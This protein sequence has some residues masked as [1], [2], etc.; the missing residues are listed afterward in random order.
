M[1]ESA[2]R[3]VVMIIVLVM[4]AVIGF[5]VWV[6]FLTRM[7]LV[8]VGAVIA[9]VFRD[10]NPNRA[11]AGL[12]A[13]ITF[14]MRGFRMIAGLADWRVGGGRPGQDQALDLL[15][16]LVEVGFAALFWVLVASGWWI[17]F[18]VG[19]GTT[20]KRAD[21]PGFVVAEKQEVVPPP[22][23]RSSE[24]GPANRADEPTSALARPDSRTVDV[25]PGAQANVD[26]D[27][28]R[29]PADVVNADTIV[30][31]G[32][33]VRRCK[34]RGSEVFNVWCQMADLRIVGKLQSEECGSDWGE[35]DVPGIARG[36][37]LKLTLEMCGTNIDGCKRGRPSVHAYWC[38]TAAGW[39]HESCKSWL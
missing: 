39:G 26:Q 33:F 27:S 4:W 3:N 17:T 12:E 14:Y 7:M 24:I 25:Q 16:T 35:Q 20:L 2:V 32:M 28:S 1:I 29:W 37:T 13:A 18:T 30:W 23:P 5:L 21:F 10:R 34:E 19:W 31:C 11:Q 38:T 6:P 36:M 8:F 9:A 22:L 15:R